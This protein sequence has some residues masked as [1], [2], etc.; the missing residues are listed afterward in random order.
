MANSN[1]NDKSDELAGTVSQKGHEAGDKARSAGAQVGDSVASAADA[2]ARRL[3]DAT[4]RGSEAYDDAMDDLSDRKASL[5]ET[6]RRNPLGAAAGALLVGFVLG[7][8][9]L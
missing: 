4:R 9:V 1:I 6:I 2:G 3:K 8:F 5:E 7:R